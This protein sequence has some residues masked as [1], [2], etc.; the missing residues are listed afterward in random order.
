MVRNLWARVTC[1]ARGL[2]DVRFDG[3]LRL[4]GGLASLSS[5]E[6]SFEPVELSDWSCSSESDTGMLL[7]LCLEMSLIHP[8]LLVGF[9]W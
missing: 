2:L 9:V 8:F 6:V 7:F 3:F 4:R 1:G 5:P